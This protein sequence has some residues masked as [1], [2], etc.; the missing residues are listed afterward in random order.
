MT[1]ATTSTKAVAQGNGATTSWPFTFLIP[2]ID[3]IVVSLVDIASGN[4]TTIAPAYFSV[5][6]FGNP[7]GGSV[8]YPLSGAPVAATSYVVVQRIVPETQ[9]TDFTLQ[10]AVYPTDIEDA[11][12][13]VT[14]ICQQLQSQVNQSIVFSPADTVT[15]VLPSKTAR[16][17]LLLGFN[18]NGDPVAVSGPLAAGTTVSAAMIPVV[19]APTTAD[20]LVALGLPGTLLDL[21]IPS[22]TCWEYDAAGAAPTGFVFPIGQ[23]C[24]PTYPNYRAKLVAA[25]SP[26]GTNGVDPLM[27]DRRS[28]VGAGK[29]NM[30]GVDNGLLTG[31]TTLGNVIGA[32]SV[33]LD[34]NGLPTHI[35]AVFAGI[36]THSHAV[37]GANGAINTSTSVAAAGHAF[38][39]VGVAIAVS[40]A[41]T[42]LTVRDTA[43]GGGTANI[44]APTGGNNPHVNVQ[45]TFICNFILKVH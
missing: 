5:T 14:M 18:S 12:D 17:N 25:G 20:A 40:A 1:L 28:T 32:Q 24:T 9:E 33:T 39:D 15:P 41:A 35:H 44:T 8:T 13:Y 27:P 43:G 26:Y 45:P 31:G 42:G 4:I 6:G 30:G 37:S 22:G 21:L 36:E 38:A 29:S 16:A 7:T 3:S 34:L 10:G 2:S 11:L 19:T 23:P